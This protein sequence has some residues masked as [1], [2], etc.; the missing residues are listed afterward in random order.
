MV[1]KNENFSVENQQQVIRSVCK[2][3]GS[4]NKTDHEFCCS[5]CELL[6]AVQNSQWLPQSESDFDIMVK[7]HTYMDHPDFKKYYITNTLTNE[8]TFY[9]EGLQCSSCVHLIEKMPEFYNEV[10]SSEINFGLS[11]LVIRGTEK[12]SLAHVVAVMHELGYRAWPLSPN[13]NT[14]DKF[15]KENRS[16]IKKIAVAGA[17]AGNIMLFVVPVYG[18]LTGTYATVFNWLSFLLFLPILFYSAIPFYQGAINSIK[19]QVINVD[20][21]ITIAMLA[22]FIF[23][24]VNLVRG[25]GEIYFDSTASFIFLILATRFLVKRVQQKSLSESTLS[26]YIPIQSVQFR[27]KEGISSKPS[28]KIEVGDIL[29]VEANQILPADGTIYSISADIDMSLLNGES[30]PQT[31]AHG[32]KVFAG[33]R[34]LNKAFDMLV[35]KTSSETEIGKI[36]NKLER[37]SLQKTKFVTLSDNLAQWLIGIVF[38]LAVIFFIFYGALVDYQEALNRSLALIVLACPCALAFGTPLTY[39]M[40]LRKAR[41]KGILIKN[42]NVFEKVLQMKTI[43]FDKTGTLTSGHLSLVQFFPN[44]V[45]DEVKSLI[46]GLES[47]S[48]H[49]IAFAFR[50]AWKN[51]QPKVFLN[52]EEKLGLGVSGYHEGKHYMLESAQKREE[53]GLMCVT[54]KKN[55]QVLGYFYFSDELHNDTKEVISSLVQKNYQVGILSGDRRFIVNKIA[56]ETKINPSLVFSELSPVEKQLKLLEFKDVCMIGDGANDALALQSALV[57]IAVKGSVSLS[58]NSCDVY[59]TKSGL[60]SLLFLIEISRNA[61]D[62][63]KRNLFFALVYNFIGGVLALAGFI[64][65]LIAAILMPVSS[66]LILGST[67]LGVKK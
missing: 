12:M 10:L 5:A 23:S 67:L 24:T 53:N 14:I 16:F 6:Y 55:D 65:P 63:L 25:H 44:D 13:E 39:A 7:N 28:H 47:Q 9:V 48:S 18:G 2:H 66:G 37:E 42:G 59:F 22:G 54:L 17:C 45:S 30:L 27:T 3:C 58:L 60:K 19:Y 41:E 33:T 38:S 40:S 26:Q 32:M 21:P 50:N 20:L 56:A 62:T 57:G 31:F 4:I 1:M 64:N 43:F 49:P 35:E 46:L 52:L 51:T 29:V 11:T 61:Q 8:Y 34:A 15:K 36:I